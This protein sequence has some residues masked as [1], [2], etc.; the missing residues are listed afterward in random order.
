MDG[1]RACL[2]GGVAM[3]ARAVA[4]R[5]GL[6][7]VTTFY[8]GRASFDAGDFSITVAGRTGSHDGAVAFA[9]EAA[10]PRDRHRGGGAAGGVVATRVGYSAGKDRAPGSQARRRA[11]QA[12]R[13]ARATAWR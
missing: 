13:D 2:R 8:T 6:P 12:S 9:R 10:R 1:C 4:E 11:S 7:K 3:S 5:L